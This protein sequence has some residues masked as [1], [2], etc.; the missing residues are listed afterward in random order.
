MT[1]EMI[2]ILKEKD[3]C[4]NFF[5][6]QRECV[7]ESTKEI[8]KAIENINKKGYNSN[9]SDLICISNAHRCYRKPNAKKGGSIMTEADRH[10][11]LYAKN[12]YQTGDQIEDMRKI[13]G[14]R[15]MVSSDHISIGDISSVLIKIVWNYINHEKD[16]MI[17]F[18][19]CI[20]A[21]PGSM[22]I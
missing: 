7:L 14:E 19:I 22:D 17:S 2:K 10:I 4:W 1:E 21:I 6:R 11:F 9:L 3:R 13:I 5:N 20:Q 8:R 15:S 16:F 18:L 12:H